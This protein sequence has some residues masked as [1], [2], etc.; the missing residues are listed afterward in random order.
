MRWKTLLLITLFF[1]GI[2]ESQTPNV[3]P[4]VI[5]ALTE[6]DCLA[7]NIYFE[8]RGEGKQGQQAVAWVVMHRVK[9]KRFPNTIC[10]VVWQR[11]LNPRTQRYVPQFSWTRG[12]KLEAPKDLRA[13][14]EALKTARDVYS[15]RSH[16]IVSGATHYH[17]S[18]VR[19]WWSCA[20]ARTIKIGRHI[21]YRSLQR[22]ERGNCQMNASN[23]VRS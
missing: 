1:T 10:E 8:A 4:H 13:W 21:F 23:N 2:E 3:P 15:G 12:R 16:D 22:N 17:A 18:Y 6:I 20:L 5:A 14:R 9:S 7:K 11:K 19:P